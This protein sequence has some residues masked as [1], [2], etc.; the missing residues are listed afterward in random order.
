MQ[1]SEN[2]LSLNLNHFVQ[3]V[4]VKKTGFLFNN[5]LNLLYTSYFTSGSNFCWNLL[6]LL[7]N[8]QVGPD[9]A[10]ASIVLPAAI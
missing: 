2:A 7:Y 3:F 1:V 8:V 6:N 5:K 10:K 4:K 9:V